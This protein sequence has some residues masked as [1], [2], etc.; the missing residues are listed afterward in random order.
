MRLSAIFDIDGD[1]CRAV[2][3]SS[4]GQERRGERFG[5]DDERGFSREKLK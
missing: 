2:V 1:G 5:M 4:G 3:G